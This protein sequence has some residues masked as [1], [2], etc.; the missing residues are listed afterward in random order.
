M[1]PPSAPPVRVSP[2]AAILFPKLR[3]YFA[4]FLNEGCPAHL[5]ILS[6]PTCVGFGT[7]ASSLARSFSRQRSSFEFGS[8]L[9]SPIYRFSAFYSTD[10]PLLQPT[11]FDALFQP[12]AQTAF[13]VTPSLKRSE[14]VQ[15]F[16]PV[17]H[18]LCFSPRL[19]SRLTQ[20]GRAYLW[21]P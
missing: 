20:S 6:P 3:I 2:S 7:G 18:R 5:R 10:L 9:D 4:E 1:P 14:T 15:E 16:S 17:V 12:R 11:C 13:C 8:S 21:K 19:R